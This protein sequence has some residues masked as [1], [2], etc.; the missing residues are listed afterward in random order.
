MKVVKFQQGG[1]TPAPE[2]VPA[3]QGGQDPIMEIAQIFAQA[4]QANDCN[5]LA[6]GAE[7][8]LQLVSQAA[9]GPQGPVGAPVEGQPVFKKGGK[10]VRRKKCGKK[11]NGGDISGL[12]GNAVGAMAGKK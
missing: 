5:M 6:Q 4:L 11:Q 8:F 1:P 10:M 9:G 7:M 12:I 2:P 3:P